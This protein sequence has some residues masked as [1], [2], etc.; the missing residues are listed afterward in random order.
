M[1]PQIEVALSLNV[2]AEQT[3]TAAQAVE[4][5]A[6]RESGVHEVGAYERVLGDA[7][8]GDRT[9]FARQDYIEEAWRIVDPILAANTP[10]I[11]YTGQ[12]WGPSE[13]NGPSPAGGWQNPIV[14]A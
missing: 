5:S 14:Q 7:I 1:S 8:E 3:E 12:T 10:V 11:E 4:L 2:M 6:G 9:L 13:T